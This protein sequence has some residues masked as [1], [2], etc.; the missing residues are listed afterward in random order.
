M[1]THILDFLG[2]SFVNMPN[3]ELS[4]LLVPHALPQT[5]S[6]SQSVEPLWG[7]PSAEWLQCLHSFSKLPQLSLFLVP[8]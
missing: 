6:Q 7:K 4:S 2:V 5:C 1:P 8:F 3:A